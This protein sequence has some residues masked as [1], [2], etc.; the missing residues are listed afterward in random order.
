MVV[1]VPEFLCAFDDDFQRAA[2]RVTF[3]L[4][5]AVKAAFLL[6]NAT[7]IWAKASQAMMRMKMTMTQFNRQ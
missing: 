2:K 6:E 3:G 7:K 4:Q 1:I 5:L